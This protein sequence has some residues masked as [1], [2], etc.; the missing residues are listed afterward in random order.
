MDSN[1]LQEDKSNWWI[2]RMHLQD[3]LIAARHS[4]D[5]R[6]QVGAV[7]V[8]PSAGVVLSGWN[9][10]PQDLMSAGYPRDPEQK[11]YCTE[12]AERAVLFK[13]LQNGIPASSM[14]LYCTWAAC[15]ECSRT[16]IQFGIPRVVTLR[17][18]VEATDPRWS[19]SIRAGLSM[20]R[21]CGIKVVG[22]SGDIGTKYSI[23]FSGRTV[24][25]EDL[26]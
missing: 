12:H 24:G 9:H 25:N 5:P 15:A 11:N 6:T 26:L 10:I 21:D 18:L 3:A 4:T 8:L 17:R 22:W 14:T 7:L 23:R 16:I 2:D 13:C 19:E 20:M 1:L